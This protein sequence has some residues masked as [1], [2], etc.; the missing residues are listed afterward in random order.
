MRSSA[1]IAGGNGRR[2]DDGSRDEAQQGL[3]EEEVRPAFRFADG[4][5]PRIPTARALGCLRLQSG[6]PRLWP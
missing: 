6:K 2:W 4:G 3:Q 5:V 1:V